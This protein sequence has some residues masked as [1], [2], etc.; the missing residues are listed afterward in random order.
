MQP[1]KNRYGRLMC[2]AYI[3]PR[4]ALWR[5]KSWSE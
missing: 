5:I 1:G 3:I 4:S 2:L